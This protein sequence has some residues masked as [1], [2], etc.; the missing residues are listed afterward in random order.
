MNEA[1]R[2][3]QLEAACLDLLARVEAQEAR[4]AELEA[5]CRRDLVRRRNMR[6]NGRRRDGLGTIAAA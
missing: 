3:R 6:L 4:I 1:Q 5:A 2:I